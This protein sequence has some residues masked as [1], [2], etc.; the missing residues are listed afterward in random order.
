VIIVSKKSLQKYDLIQVSDIIFVFS[1]RIR[2]VWQ[3]K[4][5]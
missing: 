2:K 4:R 3:K 5:N 1:N